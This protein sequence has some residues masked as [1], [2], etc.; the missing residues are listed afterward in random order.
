MPLTRRTQKRVRDRLVELEG[1][2]VLGAAEVASGIGV[3]RENY[4]QELLTIV[5]AMSAGFP[6]PPASDEF[7]SRGKYV[8]ALA[9]CT[10]SVRNSVPRWA[11]FLPAWGLASSPRGHPTARY[12][13]PRHVFAS[14]TGRRSR[15][16][17]IR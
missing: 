13:S 15:R 2:G 8:V 4:H 1:D 5:S 12:G 9:E 3:L 14:A 6:P 7:G 16:L 17:P 10:V 11:S